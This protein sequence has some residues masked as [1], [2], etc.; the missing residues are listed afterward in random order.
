MKRALFNYK[1]LIAQQASNYPGL[2]S[3]ISK[4]MTGKDWFAA[5]NTDIVIDGFPRCANTYATFAFDI[6]QNSRLNIAHHIH[7]KSQ[8]ITAAKYNLP[9]IL[10]IRKPADCISSLLVRQPKYKVETLFKGYSFLYGGLAKMDTFIV[11]DFENIL[12][13]YGSIIKSVN[14]KFNTTFNLYVKNEENENKLK[15]IIHTQ[16]ELKGATDSLQ[17]V[18]YPDAERK[19]V[20]LKIKEDLFSSKYKVGLDY[21][22]EIYEALTQ[23][24]GKQN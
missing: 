18:A 3:P 16:D 5:K 21:C 24:I 23:K 13:D 7:K 6:A 9:A 2:F 22:N 15:E 20:S 12:N 4:L 14:A 10:L 1:Y 11:A 17:R 8:F 19:K